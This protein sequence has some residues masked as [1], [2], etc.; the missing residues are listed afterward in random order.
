MLSL[1]RLVQEADELGNGPEVMA[2]YLDAVPWASR[3]LAELALQVAPLKLAVEAREYACAIDL[4]HPH[5]RYVTRLVNRTLS[6]LP[7]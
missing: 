4:P 1:D 7:G 3:R 6:R 2:A 5:T